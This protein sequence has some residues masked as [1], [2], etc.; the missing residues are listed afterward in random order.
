MCGR[1]S[2]GKHGTH[3][4]DPMLRGLQNS[5]TI[6][7]GENV[8]F[9]HQLR[10][11]SLL[12]LLYVII[13][14]TI[15]Y[16]HTSTTPPPPPPPKKKKKKKKKKKRKGKR[17]TQNTHMHIRKKK[18]TS[19]SLPSYCV[20]QVAVKEVGLAFLEFFFLGVGGWGMRRGEGE[21]GVPLISH[22]YCPFCL[23]FISFF[24]Y[25]YLN[26]FCLFVLRLL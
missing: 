15:R 1:Q 22:K 25:Y 9:N 3:Q 13:I 12:S 2:A 18:K 10:A 14:V 4:L 11:C 6:F 19:T 5:S 17:K 7:W 26:I 8:K 21:G 24:L 16:N 20:V 23:F